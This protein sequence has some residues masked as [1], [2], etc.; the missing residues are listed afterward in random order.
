MK[1]RAENP[2]V[3]DFCGFYWHSTR[4]ARKGTD[5]IYNEGQR[6]FQTVSKNNVIGWGDCKEILFKFKKD[7]DQH[8][9]NMF[10]HF[11][12]CKDC[13]KCE[14]WDNVYLQHLARVNTPTDL[15]TDAEMLSAVEEMEVDGAH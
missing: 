5:W 9:R 6:Q 4:L 2:G 13:G 14:Y 11:T 3:T 8:Y 10:W 7:M 1:H 15:V 12:H